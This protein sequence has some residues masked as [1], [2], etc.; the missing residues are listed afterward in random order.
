M[1]HTLSIALE[2]P[3]PGADPAKID[4]K[5]VAKASDVLE[6][7]AKKLQVQPLLGFS[8]AAGEEPPP[9]FSARE[10]LRTVQT[11]RAHL[12]QNRRLVA[13][14]ERV[15]A[16]LSAFEKILSKAAAQN[17]GWRLTGDV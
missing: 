8:G 10:G 5:A 3:V 12:Q 1:A 7:L 17:V 4:G 13:D 14:S 2:R 6:A 16:D 11:L 9:F 15:A